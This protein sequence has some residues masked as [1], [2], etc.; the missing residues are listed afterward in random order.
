MAQTAACS[1]PD[2]LYLLAHEE[3][4]GRGS[5]VCNVLS[6]AIGIGFGFGVGNPRSRRRHWHHVLSRCRAR[7]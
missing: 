3:L 1:S 5:L 7:F 6:A 2:D 4:V